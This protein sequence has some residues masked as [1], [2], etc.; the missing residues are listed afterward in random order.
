LVN[1]PSKEKANELGIRAKFNTAVPTYDNLQT[2][3]QLIAD[4]IIKAEIEN[5]YRLNEV[6]E[7]HKKSETGRARGKILLQIRST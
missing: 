1:P 6:R 5:T 2:L 4:G 7:A 3:A